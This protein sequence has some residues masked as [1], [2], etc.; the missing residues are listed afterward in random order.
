MSE[1]QSLFGEPEKN[2]GAARHSDPKTSK[3]AAKSVEATELE[4]V[5]LKAIV[6]CGKRGTTTEELR[7]QL[8][9]PLVSVSPRI[10][11]LTRKGLIKDSGAVRKNFSGRS[12]IVWIASE[13]PLIEKKLPKTKKPKRGAT[14]A[15]RQY[16][17]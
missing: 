15:A 1:Q 13:F 2:P 17:D 3:D 4:A 14:D 11:P 9:I 6:A 5:V 12:A 7:N 8:D 16:P 10:A